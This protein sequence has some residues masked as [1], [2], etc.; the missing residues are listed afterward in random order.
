VFGG[1]WSPPRG[2]DGRNTPLP[3]V[4]HAPLDTGTVARILQARAA[5]IEP[6]ALGGHS[7][8]RGAL[9]TG[10]ARGIHPSHLK[11]LGR[12]KSYAV[13]DVQPEF[14]DL[15]EGRPLSGVL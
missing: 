8:K 7:L 2:R 4:G 9:S 11:H 10:M 3:R 1:I 12:H 15:F 5:G 6:K 14:G 13:L